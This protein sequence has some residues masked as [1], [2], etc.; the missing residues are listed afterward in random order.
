MKRGA[1]P[2]T[3]G[4]M[5]RLRL[6]MWLAFAVLES[7]CVHYYYR[8][9]VEHSNAISG[10]FYDGGDDGNGGNNGIGGLS[11]GDGVKFKS[12]SSSPPMRT[13]N[14]YAE[15]FGAKD[16]ADMNI[17]IIRT[18]NGDQED[19][20]KFKPVLDA[21]INY[22][23]IVPERGYPKN[24]HYVD[25]ATSAAEAEIEKHDRLLIQGMYFMKTTNFDGLKKELDQNTSADVKAKVCLNIYLCNRRIPYI[26]TLIMGLL[27]FSKPKEQKYIQNAEIHLLNTEKREPRLH[28]KYLRETLSKLPFVHTTHNIT[29]KDEI[30]DNIKDRPLIFRESFISD[31]ISGLKI[32][33]ESGLPYCVMMEEDAAVPVDFMKLL[34]EQV[35][36]PL[37]RRDMIREDGT[38]G[39]SVL[40]LYSYYNL[41]HFSYPKL[42]SPH[43]SRNKYGEDAAK[44]NAAR[45]SQGLPPHKIQFNIRDKY[46]KYGTVAMMY[47]RESAIRLVEYLQKVGVDPI[48]NADEFMNADEYFP[49]E[50]GID[51]KHVAPSLVNHIGYYSERMADVRSRGMFSQL[52]TD[53]RF[54]YDPGWDLMD[55]FE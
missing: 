26:N 16:P 13:S 28:F 29:Y 8:S 46:Y 31:E 20:H 30:Y 7:T 15:V 35:I 27:S 53:V 41:V 5:S 21:D 9:Y 17:N 22:E 39:I 14:P 43:Y 37:E 33:I 40:S 18:K 49:T 48:H 36:D 38:G 34:Q 23:G 4:R 1:P 19:I 12:S 10:I 51:R 45:I 25:Y 2:D 50:F 47:T 11:P 32:C 3:Y 6:V 42:H 52:N 55:W 24:T 44:V 54:M